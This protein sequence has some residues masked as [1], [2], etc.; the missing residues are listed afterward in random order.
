MSTSN[1]PAS[2][3]RFFGAAVLFA[4]FAVGALSGTAVSEMNERRTA[5]VAPA[6][7][8]ACKDEN[9][10]RHKS[11]LDDLGLTPEQQ[12]RVDAILA[13]RKRQ[14]DLFW[15]ENKPRMEQI[16]DS[17]R[18]EIRAVLTPE[19]RAE[20]DRRRAERRAQREAKARADSAAARP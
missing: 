14:L 3:L 15:N 6:T 9:S 2:R 1:N 16:V 8:D 5:T 11:M 7:N 12:E 18:A 20:L 19:Q 10:G 4:T 13:D 17:T